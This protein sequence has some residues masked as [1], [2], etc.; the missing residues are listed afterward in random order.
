MVKDDAIRKHRKLWNWIAEE[1]KNRT[2]EKIAIPVDK[3]DYFTTHNIPYSERPQQDC[4][5]C[6]YTVECEYDC[7]EVK[8][9]L[10]PIDWTNNGQFDNEC[11]FTQFGSRG[12]Y[13]QFTYNFVHGNIEKCYEIAEIIANLPE[14]NY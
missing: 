10:C 14:R 4:Y 9:N 3:D 13:N 1:N 7:T 12:L 2:S 11:C 5:A 6:Q 8:C